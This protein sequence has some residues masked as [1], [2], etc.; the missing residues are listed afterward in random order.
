MAKHL[1]TYTWKHGVLAL[2]ALAGIVALARTGGPSAN[3]TEP[4]P[5]SVKRPATMVL[6]TPAEERE[7]SQSISSD[8]TIKPRFYALVS[9]R[10]NGIIDDIYVREGDVVKA[11][12]T[13]LFAVDNEKLQQAVDHARQSL[14]I[15]RST[16][17]ERKANYDKAEADLIQ[18]E[19]DFN[20]T[21]SLYEEKV[22]PLSQYEAD[23]TKVIQLEAML[24]VSATGITL[25][26]QN[27]TLSAID[28]SMTEKD[29]RDSIMLAP[30]DGIVSARYMEPGEMGSPGKNVLRIDDTDQLK[31]AA[32]LPGQFYPHIN[33]GT[34]IAEVSVLGR[35]IG[36]FPVSYKAPS[37]D[38]ALRTFEVWADIPGDGAYAVPGAQCVIRIIL[39]QTTGIGVPRDAVQFRAGKYWVFVPDNDVAK[40]IEVKPG[41]ETDGW[42]ELIDS[43]LQP[44]DKVVTQGQFLLENG[45]PIRERTGGN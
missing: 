41:L 22:V 27:V 42:T 29:L 15:A 17:N 30:I 19:K 26:E 13:K 24:E 1:R 18:A 45:Y 10:I 12:Q 6:L 43:P 35:K 9:P 21:K 8:G 11:G 3:S 40:M 28:L 25:A 31:A 38:S 23:E 33:T 16:L 36:D 5:E 37:I 14:V 44:G 20:R 4:I 34:S 7:F 2:I 32:Y 39:N